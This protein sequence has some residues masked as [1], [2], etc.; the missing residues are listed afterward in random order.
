MAFILG[1]LGHYAT[2]NEL[3]TYFVIFLGAN[4][5]GDLTA[6]AGSVLAYHGYLDWLP[7]IL[8]TFLGSFFG[9][10]LIFQIGKRL[11]GTKAGAWIETRIPYREKITSYLSRNSLEA[12]TLSKFI[13][14]FNI[15]TLFLSGYLNVDQKTFIKSAFMATAVWI[16]AIIPIG[17]ALGIAAQG[18]E[19]FAWRKIESV[20]ALG[21][22]LIIVI[23]LLLRKVA[24]RIDLEIQKEGAK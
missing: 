14:G 18:F 19:Y 8:A 10:N 1:F 5:W 9:D 13:I 21:V 15:P 11:R 20:I 3:G 4:I 22:V 24:A 2:I 16:A 12:L 23:R 7:L 17:Y 6:I